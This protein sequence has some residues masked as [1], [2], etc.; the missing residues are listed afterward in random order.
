MVFCCVLLY[1]MVFYG[2]SF[3]FVWR[4]LMYD[5]RKSHEAQG[6]PA[7]FTWLRPAFSDKRE[8]LAKKLSRSKRSYVLALWVAFLWFHVIRWTCCCFLAF[9]MPLPAFIILLDFQTQHYSLGQWPAL[10]ESMGLAM[11]KSSNCKGKCEWKALYLREPV[12]CTPNF[13]TNLKQLLKK[14]CLIH[15]PFASQT[16]AKCYSGVREMPL[17]APQRLRL[18]RRVETWPFPW[19]WRWPAASPWALESEAPGEAEAGDGGGFLE[20]GPTGLCLVGRLLMYWTRTDWC[21]L[22]VHMKGFVFW[23]FS[24]KDHWGSEIPTK[25]CET[26]SRR[27]QIPSNFILTLHPKNNPKTLQQKPHQKSQATW[28]AKKRLQLWRFCCGHLKNTVALGLSEASHT[29]SIAKP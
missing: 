5:S 26:E 23:I 13:Q 8:V 20:L 3:A 7:F 22:L 21:L 9:R 2:V 15:N 4:C 16:S 24:C 28:L 11:K 1:F 10:H 14:K 25:Y 17:S 18:R 27:K 19:A 29:V 6:D 12:D